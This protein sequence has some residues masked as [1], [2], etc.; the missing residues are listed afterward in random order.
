M[1]SIKVEGDNVAKAYSNNLRI[2]VKNAKPVCKSVRGLGL[3]VAKQFLEDVLK[4]KRNIGGRYYPKT[5]KEVLNIILS[6]EKNAEFKNLDIKNMYI[7]HIASLEGTHMHRRR[8]KRNIGSRIKAAH[9]EVILKE[10]TGKKAVVSKTKTEAKIKE[11]IK[12]DLKTQIT[13]EIETKMKT[14]IAETKTPVE[15]KIEIKKETKPEVEE[16]KTESKIPIKKEIK[17]EEKIEVKKVEI[18]EL[19]KDSE[20]KPETKK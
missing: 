5:T 20:V 1:Y 15:K 7:L 4:A 2:S 8:H 10:R 17:V 12:S 19:K 9:L 6:A 13:K 16:K 3:P 14:Q 11:G 18:K